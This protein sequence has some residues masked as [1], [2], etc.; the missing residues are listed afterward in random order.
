MGIESGDQGVL[1]ATRKGLD[2][3]KTRRALEMSDSLGISNHVLFMV[4]L[5]GDTLQSIQN[6][7]RYIKSIPVDSV[8]FSVATPFPGPELHQFVQD[9]GSW[10][11]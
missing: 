1:D 8:Q 11:V 4:G 10:S 9:R 6:T 2:L 3:E 7:A 5:A